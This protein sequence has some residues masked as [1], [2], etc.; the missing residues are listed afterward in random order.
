[1]KFKSILVGIMV[2]AIM[3]ACTSQKEE[4]AEKIDSQISIEPLVEDVLSQE[5][6]AKLTPEDVIN[7][8]MEGNKRFVNNDL[9]ARDHTKQVRQSTFGQY[10]K[11][12]ILSCLDSRIPVEDVFDKGIGD[13]FVGR[14][15]GNFVNTDLLGSMEFGCKVVGSKIIMVL[16]HESC[17]AIKATIDKVELGNITSMLKNINPAVDMSQSYTGQKSSVNPEYVSLV[18]E[19]NVKNT[20]EVIRQNSE[21]LKEMERKGEIKIVGAIYDMNSGIV[22][23][24]N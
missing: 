16:G 13:V 8:L 14:V 4:S 19:N 3:S 5:E 6:L 11:A 18:S 24:V 9:T 7:S 10:P 17:G 23:V 15:A 22:R 20:I 21:I 12:V 2:I 1:M